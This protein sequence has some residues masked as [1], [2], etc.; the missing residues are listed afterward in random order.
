MVFVN[1]RPH[2]VA[3]GSDRRLGLMSIQQVAPGIDP[4][5][6]RYLCGTSHFGRGHIEV[7]FYEREG[8]IS[9]YAVRN[10]AQSNAARLGLERIAKSLRVANRREDEAVVHELF[11]LLSTLNIGSRFAEPA[12]C[13]ALAVNSRLIRAAENE[14]VFRAFNRKYNRLHSI[15]DKRSA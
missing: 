15:F 7:A 4:F 5:A 14:V 3:M 8:D 2:P 11:E 6:Y 1:A 13:L 9:F 12:E 10:V